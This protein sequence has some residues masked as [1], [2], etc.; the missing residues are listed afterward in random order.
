M[1]R[2]PFE[3]DGV[4][5]LT[6]IGAAYLAFTL[7]IGFAALNT[8]NNS[9][10]I[11]LSVMLGALLWSG[12]ASKGGLRQISVEIVG[13]TEAWAGRDAEVT[14]RVENRSRIWSVRDVVVILPSLDKPLVLP[15]VLRRSV[16]DFSRTARFTRRGRITFEEV[17]LYTRYPFALFV[18]KRRTAAAGEAIV[19]PRLLSATEGELMQAE[20]VGETESTHRPGHGADL[21]GWREYVRGDSLRHVHWKKSASLGRWIIRQPA[22]ESRRAVAVAI[23]SFMPPGRADDFERLVSAAATLLYD[24]AN[25]QMELTVYFPHITVHGHG[26]NI[27]GAVFRELALLEGTPDVKVRFFPADA[28]LFT[29]RPPHAAAIA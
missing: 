8:G 14:I 23:D 28:I 5:R 4:V 3:F 15:L 7:V 9:L 11:G 6:T 25:E 24:A 2:Q 22:E 26:P 1:P 10:Y 18:K 27:R 29:L 20:R 21:Y 17:D 19:F 13:M 16:R 12:L